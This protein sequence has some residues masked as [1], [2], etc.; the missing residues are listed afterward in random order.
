MQWPVLITCW[1]LVIALL[2]AD[3]APVKRFYTRTR[4]GKFLTESFSWIRELFN[5]INTR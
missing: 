2:I 3:T 5:R 1:V 4:L